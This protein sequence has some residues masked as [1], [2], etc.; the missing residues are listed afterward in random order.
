[1][2]LAPGPSQWPLLGVSASAFG[3]RQS[4]L[5]MAHTGVF[6]QVCSVTLLGLIFLRVNPMPLQWLKAPAG[7]SPA[8]PGKPSHLLSLAEL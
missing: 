6:K 5:H 3:P 1:M 2:F 4:S 7:P 8:P